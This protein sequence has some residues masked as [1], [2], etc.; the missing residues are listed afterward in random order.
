[1]KKLVRFIKSYFTA[2][3]RI[4]YY[5]IFGW[6]YKSGRK[7]LSKIMA[8]LNTALQNKLKLGSINFKDLVPEDI[9]INLSQIFGVNGNT[10]LYESMVI[11]AI[12][13]N[14][15]PLTILEIGTFDGRTTLNLALNTSDDCVI[16]TL[17][18]PVSHKDNTS[19]TIEENEKQ[20]INK[21]EPGLRFKNFSQSG[22]IVQLFGDSAAFDF[23][24]LP[25]PNFIFIDGS[26]AYE[27]VINDSLK[28]IDMLNN[29]GIILWHDYGVWQG[30]TKALEYLKETNPAFKALLTISE[31]SL[32]YIVKR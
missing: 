30:V 21:P 16:Y 18:L 12:A 29:N 6:S 1:M 20:Y 14:H 32:A 28:C 26:H 25:K 5:F 4:F 22:K 2:F 10:S 7:M 8:S 23:S 24:N 3:I 31:T 9:S 15:K 11:S 17:D 13:A 27:Y 19:F